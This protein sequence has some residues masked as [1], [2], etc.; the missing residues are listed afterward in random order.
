MFTPKMILNLIIAFLCIILNINTV[1]AKQPV[2]IKK[3]ST[4]VIYKYVD[5]SGVVH[6][7]NKPPQSTDN[8]LYS[9]SYYKPSHNTSRPDLNLTKEDYAL[10]LEALKFRIEPSPTIAIVPK[11]TKKAAKNKV[12]KKVVKSNPPT[13]YTKL[14]EDTAT[15]AK[16]PT[17]LLHA[18]I[19]VESG[20][21][22]EAV[23][24]KGAVGLMQLMPETAKAYGVTDLTDP[25][26]NV[27]GGAKYL[28][29]LL[30]LF[31][32]DLSL[33]LAAYNAGENAVIK[34]GNNIPPYPETRLYVSKVMDIYQNSLSD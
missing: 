18:I 10:L 16:L 28:Q 30:K 32:N 17:A 6:L 21:N 1:L 4:T 20:Y 12:V 8:L 13:A 22:S 25:T 15:Q 34:H 19:Q 11:D 7:T 24:P 33:A 29:Y 23:S 27:Q 14:L 26:E 31:N 9:R 3:R 5:S 2:V